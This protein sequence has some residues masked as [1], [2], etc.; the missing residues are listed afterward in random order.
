MHKTNQKQAKRN[1]MKR[2]NAHKNRE[3][4]MAFSNMAFGSLAGLFL[5]NITNKRKAK[6]IAC[7]FPKIK[8]E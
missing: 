7:M 4:K 2:N 5:R 3:P 8:T 6:Q 1:G